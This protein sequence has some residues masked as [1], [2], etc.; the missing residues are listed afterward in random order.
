VT[1]QNFT[2]LTTHP[3]SQNINDLLSRFSSSGSTRR[4]SNL[5]NVVQR[6][7]AFRNPRAL[8]HDPPSRTCDTPSC[9]AS[10]T[11][12]S[13]S[14][15]VSAIRHQGRR[16]TRTFVM[17]LCMH[18]RTRSE[19]TRMPG[20]RE[21]SRSVSSAHEHGTGRRTAPSKIYPFHPV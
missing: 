15:P 17:H 7:W 12:S 3:L 1:C 20:V 16:R 6:H 21:T 13:L 4:P 11:T 9:Q 10:L 18:R 2:L 14:A 5:T 19:P 8:L